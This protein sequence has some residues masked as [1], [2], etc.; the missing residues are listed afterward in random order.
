MCRFADLAHSIPRPLP[1]AARELG[2]ACVRS[3]LPENWPGAPKG[4]EKL[5]W[6]Y[7]VPLLKKSQTSFLAVSTSPTLMFVAYGGFLLLG[8]DDSVLA[9]QAIAN[10]TADHLIDF[11]SPRVW[12]D[13]FTPQLQADKRFEPVTLPWMQKAGASEFCW[14]NPNEVLSHGPET[15]QPS[16]HGA[17]LYLMADGHATYF[18]AEQPLPAEEQEQSDWSPRLSYRVAGSPNQHV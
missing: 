1:R 12:R 15:W 10:D 11:G 14:L 5:C 17:F 13:E 18:P 9:V 4:A 2:C 3:Q 8:K 16:V 7:P 6:A